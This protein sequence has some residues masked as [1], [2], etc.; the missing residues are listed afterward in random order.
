[1]P[2]TIGWRDAEPFLALNEAIVSAATLDEARRA[3]AKAAA[4]RR[5]KGGQGKR[6]SSKT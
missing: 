6:G 4:P 5:K 2:D 3:C 1:M